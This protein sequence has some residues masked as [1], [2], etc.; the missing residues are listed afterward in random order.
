MVLTDQIVVNAPIDRV[1][2]FVTNAQ[3]QKMWIDGLVDTEFTD[4]QEGQLLVGAR[5]KQHLVKGHKR[6]NYVF[7]GEITAYEPSK[8]YAV[9]VWN[10]DFD[11]TIHY[12]FEASQGKTILTCKTEMQFHGSFI[13]RFIGKMAAHHNKQDMKKLLVLLERGDLA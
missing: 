1:F 13:A 2:D 7:Q 12:R 5:F 9:T 11:A 8:H 3:K 4:Q 6:T 10:A